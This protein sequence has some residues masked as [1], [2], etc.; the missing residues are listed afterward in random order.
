[1]GCMKCGSKLGKSE[2]FCDACLEKME[3]SPVKPGTVVKLPDRPTA[4]VAKKKR[5]I[6]RYFW[7]I[8][9]EMDVLHSKIRWLT[10]ALVVAILGFVLSVVMIFLLLYWQGQLDFIT[11]FLPF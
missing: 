6:R 4:P 5:P 1:M 8:E 10:C 3:K 11:R 9:G 7:N 2:V